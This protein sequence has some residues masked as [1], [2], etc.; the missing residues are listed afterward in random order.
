[1]V[2]AAI[3]QTL[4]AYGFSILSIYTMIVGRIFMG[5]ASESLQVALSTIISEYFRQDDLSL[6]LVEIY[7][8]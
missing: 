5:I 7:K 2:S 3:G 6:S 1:V 8:I 4:F